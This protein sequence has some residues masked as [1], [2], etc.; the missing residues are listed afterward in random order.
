[1][2]YSLLQM[3]NGISLAEGLPSVRQDYKDL[4]LGLNQIV[5]VWPLNVNAAIQ[6]N[7]DKFESVFVG[8]EAQLMPR[9]NRWT[10]Q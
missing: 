3:A 10:E 7:E 6:N 5:V 4:S 1:M 8:Q 9:S 2:L